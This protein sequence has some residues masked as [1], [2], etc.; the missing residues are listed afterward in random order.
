MSNAIRKHEL[1]P[2][3]ILRVWNHEVRVWVYI[4]S[5]RQNFQ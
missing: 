4:L 1:A 3:K 2:W 5:A